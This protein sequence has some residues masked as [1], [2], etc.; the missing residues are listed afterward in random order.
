MGTIQ[1]TAVPHAKHAEIASTSENAFSGN[2]NNLTNRPLFGLERTTIG[3]S[4]GWQLVGESSTK[5][6]V[7]TNAL[8]LSISGFFGS[9]NN[10]AIGSSSVLCGLLTGFRSL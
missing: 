4:S 5:G 3:S 7:G 6:E 10:G 1:F 9:S 2:Y 8:D